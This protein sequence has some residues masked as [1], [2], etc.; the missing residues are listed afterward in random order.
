MIR[1][2]EDHL[3]WWISANDGGPAE[4]LNRALNYATGDI[5]GILN[6]DDFYMPM[7][8]EQVA[9]RMSHSDSPAWVVGHTLEVDENDE[10]L[11]HPVP[12][13]PFNLDDLLTSRGTLLPA[14]ASFY[15]TC[16]FESFGNFET[17]LHHRFHFE[18]ACRL[19][20][21]GVK[22]TLIGEF[23]AGHRQHTMSMT[24]HDPHTARRER[25]Q[26]A[27]LYTQ[28]LAKRGKAA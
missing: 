7:T 21:A 4:A 26:I 28:R 20:S 12:R 1:R 27:R 18:Y 3:A 22:P 2:Y 10:V 8:L 5:V 17:M 13:E 19:L 24:R 6:A 15:R 25:K 11:D 9:G 16:V 23:L 14:A